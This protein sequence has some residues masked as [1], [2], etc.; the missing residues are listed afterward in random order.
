ML[1]F[2]GHSEHNLNEEKSLNKHLDHIED[3]MILQGKDGLALSIAFLKDIVQSLQTGQT[4]MGVSVK[5]DGKP[6]VCMRCKP[7]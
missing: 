2:S 7:Q 4:G 5:W 6:A 1:S 3:L